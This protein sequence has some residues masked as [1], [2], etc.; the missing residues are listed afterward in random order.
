MEKMTEMQEMRTRVRDGAMKLY[1]TFILLTNKLPVHKPSSLSEEMWNRLQKWGEQYPF[2]SIEVVP[3]SSVL[4]PSHP[5]ASMSFVKISCPS[6][7]QFIAVMRAVRGEEMYACEKSTYVGASIG[8]SCPKSNVKATFGSVRDETTTATITVDGVDETY[9]YDTQI[10]GISSEFIQHPIISKLVESSNF[11]A[12][13]TPLRTLIWNT[14]INFVGKTGIELLGKGT[15]NVPISQF[16]PVMSIESAS[17]NAL[18]TMIETFNTL[19]PVEFGD[20]VP[21][22][23]ELKVVPTKKRIKRKTLFSLNRRKPLPSS[24][25]TKEAVQKGGWYSRKVAESSSHSQSSSSDSE[26]ESEEEE[27][28]ESRKYPRRSATLQPKRYKDTQDY[29]YK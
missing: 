23:Q 17:E 28:G 22:L 12:L 7:Y 5:K 6:T 8:N 9:A 27:D 26:T 14:L 11:D 15:T 3:S 20:D 21:R 13:I 19:I 25:E 29:N 18:K 24:K 10:F 2:A 1:Y 4:S 16:S